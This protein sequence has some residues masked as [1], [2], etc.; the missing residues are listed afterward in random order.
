MN[1]DIT[2]RFFA[3]CAILLAVHAGSVDQAAVHANESDP[4]GHPGS[5]QAVTQKPD[6]SPLSNSAKT[7]IKRVGESVDVSDNVGGAIALVSGEESIVAETAAEV[8]E[9]KQVEVAAELRIAM[10]QEKLEAEETGEASKLPTADASRVDLLKQID[11]V[12]AQQQSAT[13]SSEDHAAQVDALKSTLTRLADGVLDEQ[14][15][16][17]I[18][19]LD[20]LKESVRNAKTKLASVDA[21]VISARSAADTAKQTADERAKTLRQLREKEKAGTAKID[22]VELA[23]LEQKLAEEML[24]LKRQQLSVE[25]ANQ[26]I[27][28]LHVEIDERKVAII[29]D[30]VVFTKGDL[31]DKID[32]LDL[33]E[34]KLKEQVVRLQNEL[35]FAERRWL[36]ARQEADSTPNAGPE[37]IEKVDSLKISQM[38]IQLELDLIN[39]RLQRLPVLKKAWERRFLVVAGKAQRKERNQWADETEQQIDQIIQ[40][41]RSRQFKLDELRVSQ[42][43]LDAKIDAVGSE[44]GQVKRWL[45]LKRDAF[46]KQ[47]EMLNRSLSVLDSSE[48]T[49]DRL[50][51]Q[52]DGEPSRTLAELAEDSWTQATNIWNYE[53]TEIDQTSLTVGKICSSV[54]M[55]FFGFLLARGISAWLGRRL[56]KWGV[57]EAAADAIESL[58]FYA[59]LVT[60]GLTALR[61]ANVP[62]TVFTFLG[63]AIAIGIGFGSQNILNNFISGLILLAERPIKVGDLIKIGDTHGNVMKIGARSTQIRTGDNQDIIVPNSSFLENEVT[64]LTR[65]DDRQRTSI[66]IGVAYGSDLDAVLRLLARAASEQ[67]GVLERPKPMVW[68]NDF[69]DNALVFQVH[70]WVQAKNLTQM[71]MIETGVRLKIDAMFRE[72]NIVIAFP[73]R[74]LHIQSPK[75]L[76]FRLVTSDPGDCDSHSKVA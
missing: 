29:G 30:V 61:Y 51:T 67:S 57:D 66:T 9:E 72:A 28:K 5:L 58:S 8:L 12:I 26:V 63:G 62:L 24:V 55:L 45:Q 4:S 65:R 31:D 43:T 40:D 17:S 16:Y 10:M 60:L 50:K 2:T 36:S 7:D 13:S 54:L 76:E 39:P 70:F 75:P 53:L 15:P 41:R 52:I 42:S 34:V 33:L 73:Q 23:E 49:L 22:T 64:N 48:R 3:V 6:L 56:P 38:S 46:D 32:D 20:G 1:P 69:G 11:V 68:F 71:R 37:L 47:S 27:A 21:S 44:N 18:I 35:Q 25:E 59:L 19:F 74:D 14:P